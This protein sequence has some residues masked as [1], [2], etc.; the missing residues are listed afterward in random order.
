LQAACRELPTYVSLGPVFPTGTK[1]TAEAVGLD[2]VKKGIEALV[3]TGIGHVTIGG[4]TLGNVEDVLD[5]GA[6]AVAVCSAVTE[7]ADPTSACRA[8]KERITAF[9]RI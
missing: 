8:L 6:A 9:R 7:V 2:Y 4:I 5:S 3:G 1:P